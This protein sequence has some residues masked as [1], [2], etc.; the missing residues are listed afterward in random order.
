MPEKNIKKIHYWNY[1]GHAHV[2]IFSCYWRADYI[3]D[4][5]EMVIIVCSF[6]KDW[7]NTR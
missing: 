1:P 5:L 7:I 2:L 3:A 4:Y 6:S